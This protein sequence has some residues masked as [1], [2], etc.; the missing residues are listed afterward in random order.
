MTRRVW[1]EWLF[2]L[3]AGLGLLAVEGCGGGGDVARQNYGESLNFVAKEGEGS[4]ASATMS[5]YPCKLGKGP[6]FVQVGPLEG[7]LQYLVNGRLVLLPAKDCS[8]KEG[9][10]VIWRVVR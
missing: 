6:I 5:R 7:D 10:E 2:T 1:L 4:V 9:D 8:L 3:G